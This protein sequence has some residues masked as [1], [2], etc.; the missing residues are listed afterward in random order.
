MK[1]KKS[2]TF[3]SNENNLLHDLN[4]YKHIKPDFH[5]LSERRPELKQCMAVTRHG[6]ATVDW[7]NPLASRLLS[8]AMLSEDFGLDVVF[9]ADRLCPPLPNRINYLCWLAEIFRLCG[10]DVADRNSESHTSVIDIGVGASCIYP[11][12]G[13]KLF[14]WSFVGSDIDEDSI[15][16][17][18][19]LINKNRMQDSIRVVIVPDSNELQGVLYSAIGRYLRQSSVA[20]KEIDLSYPVDDIDIDMK[21]TGDEDNGH[22]EGDLTMQS[23]VRAALTSGRCCFVRGPLR[24]AVAAMGPAYQSALHHLES[25]CGQS[26]RKTSGLCDAGA[27]L[28]QKKSWFTSCMTNPPFYSLEEEVRQLT[29]L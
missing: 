22:S 13:N 29:H 11:L 19:E 16:E 5:K 6:A 25:S 17:A 23:A 28:L 4:P 21:T 3:A 18:R 26:D 20:E 10:I 1:R 9:S 24:Q 15:S 7:S 2:R 14:G 8:E 12:L 27:A